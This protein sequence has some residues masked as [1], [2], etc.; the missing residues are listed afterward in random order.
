[1]IDPPNFHFHLNTRRGRAVTSDDPAFEVWLGRRSKV[2]YADEANTMELGADFLPGQVVVFAAS[3]REEIVIVPDGLSVHD[4]EAVVLARIAAAVE[5][6]D[7]E[8]VVR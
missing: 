8:L 1:M 6:R 4:Y 7:D 5:W 2:V 3:L